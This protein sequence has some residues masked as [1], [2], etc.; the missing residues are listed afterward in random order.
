MAPTVMR[1][2]VRERSGSMRSI[3]IN[4]FGM[5]ARCKVLTNVPQVRRRHWNFV[6]DLDYAFHPG[7]TGVKGIVHK[8]DEAEEDK[9]GKEDEEHLRNE[10]VKYKRA[11][12]KH[13]ACS[14]AKESHLQGGA[15]ELHDLQPTT[16]SFRHCQQTTVVQRRSLEERICEW[17]GE[18]VEPF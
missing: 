4:D 16:P 11:I 13:R 1:I 18:R 10:K 6:E 8:G 3:M 2:R 15:R 5:R 7:A 14:W 17:E 9:D 12:R